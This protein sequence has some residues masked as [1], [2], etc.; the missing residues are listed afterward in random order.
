MTPFVAL[1]IRSQGN[2]PKMENQELV[3]LSRQCSCTPV[4]FGQGFF[5]ANNNAITMEYDLTPGDI[6]LFPRLK[7]A[8]NGRRILMHLTLRM[9]RKS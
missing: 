7:S 3:Y 5:L 9:R 2:T 6:P 4:G 1:V 8:L